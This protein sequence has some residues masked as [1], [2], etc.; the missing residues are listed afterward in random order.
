MA[1]F[2]LILLHL[3][4]SEEE[5]KEVLQKFFTMKV[6]VLDGS[7]FFYIIYENEVE[8]NFR[9]SEKMAAVSINRPFFVLHLISYYY[10][11]TI[12]VL[13]SAL[14]CTFVHRGGEEGVV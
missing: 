14:P 2:L 11:I 3:P 6:L 9:G 7:Y 10:Y 8:K 1:S 5:R 13:F 4:P 12:D